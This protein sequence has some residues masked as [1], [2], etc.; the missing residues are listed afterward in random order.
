MVADSTR[1][2]V[3]RHGDQLGLDAVEGFAL[4]SAPSV[5]HARTSHS[6]RTRYAHISV[7]MSL[8]LVLLLLPAV[9]APPAIGLVLQLDALWLLPAP[10]FS[11]HYSVYRHT[12]PGCEMLLFVFFAVCHFCALYLDALMLYLVAYGQSRLLMW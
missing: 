6:A 5:H 3:H 11:I 8:R 4:S 10:A 2:E 12:P 9:L 1:R 7:D